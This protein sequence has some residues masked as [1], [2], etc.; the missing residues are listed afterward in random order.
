MWW[1]VALGGRG[2]DEVSTVCLKRRG[3]ITSA[4]NSIKRT[5][6]DHERHG[7]KGRKKKKMSPPH[8]GARLLFYG[9]SRRRGE[10]RRPQSCVHVGR[11]VYYLLSGGCFRAKRRRE[12]H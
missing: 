8:S 11:T 9:E 1:G 6:G 4:G 7:R 2:G 5:G 12:R 10:K 3:V